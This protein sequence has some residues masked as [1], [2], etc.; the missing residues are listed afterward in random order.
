M[1]EKMEEWKES[2]QRK[3]EKIRKDEIERI[4][5]ELKIKEQELTNTLRTQEYENGQFKHL[6]KVRFYYFMDLS[7][8]YLL[9]Y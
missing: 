7:H 1:E 4:S 2:E 3:F 6:K 8:I 5:L 9:L